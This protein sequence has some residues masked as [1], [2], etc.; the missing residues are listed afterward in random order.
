[1]HGKNVLCSRGT[2]MLALKHCC[3][4]VHTFHHDYEHL[5]LA[6]STKTER[7]RARDHKMGKTTEKI[8]LKKD[9]YKIAC[10]PQYQIPKG[11]GSAGHPES[12]A[13][14]MS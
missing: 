2:V 6:H 12:Y 4:R 14:T 13:I 5:T 1:M 3:D 11:K 8:R 10:A 9:N 7:N